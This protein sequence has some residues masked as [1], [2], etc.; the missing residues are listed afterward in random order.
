VSR[1]LRSPWSGLAVAALG[2]LAFAGLMNGGGALYWGH[3]CG[4]AIAQPHC[5]GCYASL[6]AAAGGL[7]AALAAARRP[8]GLRRAISRR[9]ASD[10]T[11]SGL[12]DA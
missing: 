1:S 6:A 8:G 5:A 4:H 12:S 7:M 11:G 9:R 3:V 10:V 2:A